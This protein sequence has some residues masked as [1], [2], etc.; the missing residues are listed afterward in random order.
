MNPT[1]IQ[2]ENVTK[3]Y[4]IQ[5]RATPRLG[6]WVVN[7]LF[8]HLRRVPYDALH[9]LNFEIKQGEFAGLLGVN[10]A[11]KS[12][13]LKLIAGITQPTSGTVRVRGRVASLLELGVGFHPDLSGIENIFY[14]GSIMGLSRRDI[15][16]RLEAIIDFSGLRPYL[17]EPVKHYS[18]GM[19][20]RLGC[21]VA[22]H[23]DPDI[24][25]LDEILAVGDAEFQ[26]RSLNRLL[27]LHELGTTVILVT[28]VLQAARQ[29]C[30]HLIWIETGEKQAD[31][32]A[33]EVYGQYQRH[34]N[35]LAL[36]PENP[37]SAARKLDV[38]ESAPRPRLASIFLANLDDKPVETVSPGDGVRLHFDIDA[39]RYSAQCRLVF[40]IKWH[41]GDTLFQEETPLF[42][43][44][45][46]ARQ[47]Y[48]VQAWPLFEHD[49][50]VDLA[51]LDANGGVLERRLEALTFRTQNSGV[52]LYDDVLLIP[53]AKW[54]IGMTDAP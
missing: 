19:Y 13:I 34:I 42:D 39:G 35:Q 31:G 46:I 49:M 30:D 51:I 14:N 1:V 36:P 3:R 24:I 26:Q 10:G 28:H 4:Y 16:D 23:L 41:E 44:R 54:T 33:H 29:L 45:E 38:E 6:A 52:R 27:D 37:F 40:R 50:A 53:P 32:S 47:T 15:L 2:F 11:G 17:F 5:Q 12:T 22:L 25:L 9:E 43:P 8:E 20:A 21:S 18:S 48:E 7:K